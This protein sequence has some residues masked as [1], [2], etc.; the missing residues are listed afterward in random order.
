MV[1][2]QEKANKESEWE[3]GVIF[4]LVGKRVCEWNSVGYSDNFYPNRSCK[5]GHIWG[6]LRTILNKSCDNM[7]IMARYQGYRRTIVLSIVSRETI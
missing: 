3:K 2:E 6:L 1:S 5:M 7:Y 4:G